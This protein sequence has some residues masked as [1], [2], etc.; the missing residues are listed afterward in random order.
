MAGAPHLKDIHLQVEDPEGSR[1][2]VEKAKARQSPAS[3]RRWAPELR[4]GGKQWCQETLIT[5]VWSVRSW[6]TA[7]PGRMDRLAKRK[8]RGTE[9]K[10]QS[11]MQFEAAKHLS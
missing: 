2:E 11:S 7:L 3:G 8:E 5:A 6:V 10:G 4:A 1:K 9:S